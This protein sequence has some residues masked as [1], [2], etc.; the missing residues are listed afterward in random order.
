M[1]E[2]ITQTHTHMNNRLRR[3]FLINRPSGEVK[4]TDVCS[5]CA[6][7]KVRLTHTEKY[8]IAFCFGEGQ[9]LL[10][11]TLSKKKDDP[12]IQSQTS[13]CVFMLENTGSSEANRPAVCVSAPCLAPRYRGSHYAQLQFGNRKEMNLLH[14]K[15]S[16]QSR[17]VNLTST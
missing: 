5:V 13:L 14:D 10:D 17:L 8:R 15:R 12:K 16:L 7:C 2:I 11:S 1:K 6:N 9:Q 4:H 3:T